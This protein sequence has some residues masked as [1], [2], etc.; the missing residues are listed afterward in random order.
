MSD[1]IIRRIYKVRDALCE[2]ALLLITTM[3]YT[4]HTRYVKI[5]MEVWEPELIEAEIIL[6]KDGVVK[7]V[8][9]L[10]SVLADM[11]QNKTMLNES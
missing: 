10:N 1:N 2:N 3:P 6:D 8:N 7:L 11:E 4:K 9:S 5:G